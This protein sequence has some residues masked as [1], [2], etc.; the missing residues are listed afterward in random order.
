MSPRAEIDKQIGPALSN[1]HLWWNKTLDALDPNEVIP[2]DG[3]S[4]L[5]P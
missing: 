1:Y 3:I 5:S 4:K 2:A